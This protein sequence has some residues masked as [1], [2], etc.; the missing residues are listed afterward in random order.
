MTSGSPRAIA[1]VLLLAAAWAGGAAPAPAQQVETPPIAV[2]ADSPYRAPPAE[3]LRERRDRLVDSLGTGTAIL[4]SGAVRDIESAYPQ[5][6]DFRQDNDFLYFTGLETPDSWL[7]VVARGSD[8]P[9]EILFIPERDPAEERWTG[10]KPSREEASEISGIQ[11][12]RHTEAFREMVRSGRLAAFGEP[13]WVEI[14]GRTLEQPFFRELISDPSLE[15]RDIEPLLGQLRLVKDAFEVE[16]L[17]RA[18]EITGDAQRAAMRAAEPGMYEYELEAIVEYVFRRGGAER[19][20]FPSI[21][22]SGPNSVVLHYDRSR[23]RMEEGDLVVM[24][25]GAEYAYYTA[26]VTRTIPVSGRFTDRQRAI[27]ELVL[28]AQRAG[29]EAVEPGATMADVSRA[30]TEHLRNASGDLCGEE[31]CAEHFV[32]GVGHWLGMDVHD[33][34]SYAT[35]FQPG[36]VLTVEPGVYLAEE[37]LG[38]RIEDDVLVTEDGHEVL[39]GDSPR[40]PGAIEELMEE[41]G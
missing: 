17:R 5:D 16:M 7:L 1:A 38:V 9:A 3:V 11:E 40:E 27:Y 12:V 18:I 19:V 10:A 14:D 15:P 37:N 23:R 8:R 25:I 21:I 41:D 30:A 34:G 20:G 6:S 39:S 26:D 2:R 28:G 36:M 24:D 33:V 13:L 32:H 22:G 35:P 29:I 4:R 31:S